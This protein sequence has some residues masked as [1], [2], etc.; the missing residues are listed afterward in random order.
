MLTRFTE[1]INKEHLFAEGRQVLLAISGGRDSVTLCDLVARGGY[2]FAIAHCNFHLRGD[3]SDRDEQFVRQMAQRYGVR[4]FVAQ[5]DTENEARRQGL[6]IEAAA[7]QLR[8]AFFEEVRSREGMSVVATAHHRDDAT[9]TFFINLLRGT[10]IGG[11]HG[12]RVRNG[13]I[14]RPLLLFGRDEINAY[15]SERNLAYVD[16][17]TNNETL[18]LRNKI[19]L[20]L[21]PLLREIEPS[22]DLLME[23][24]ISHLADAEQLYNQRIA[25]LRGELL[26]TAPDGSLSV[27]IAGLQAVSP[28]R[29]VLFELLRPYGF[30]EPVVEE[31]L[32][33][34]EG[35][36]GAQWLSA[37]WRLIKDRQ[38]LLLYPRKERKEEN[39]GPIDGD[40]MWTL[41]GAV[42]HLQTNTII[43]Q[44]LRLPPSKACF[45]VAAVRYPLHLRRWRQGDR[46]RPFGMKGSRL[47]SNYFI[48]N[49][50]SLQQ[51]EEAW[52]LCDADDTIL[53]LVGYRA[54]AIAAVTSETRQ[55]LMAE[56]SVER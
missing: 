7:R 9:E 36:P 13:Y 19:R 37:E 38:R 53:W 33:A 23:R 2:S 22:V 41:D 51:K 28:V 3:D 42:L 30:A 11:L 29:T 17:Y 27:D 54:S 4:C 56:Y 31:I 50:F 21:M 14:V 55:V 5:F 52:L 6:S 8:Y 32:R 15:V 35:Q 12:I 47:L 1:F 48:D 20:Q 16:D 26:H 25:E 24:N 34:L 10:G 40:G 43:P 49:K 39:I 46:F 44:S 45:D 18:Y